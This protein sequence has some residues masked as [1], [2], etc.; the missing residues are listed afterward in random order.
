[1][2]VGVFNR[3]VTSWQSSSPLY[4]SS[5]LAVGVLSLIKIDGEIGLGKLKIDLGAHLTK[6]CTFWVWGGIDICTI[7]SKIFHGQF[8]LNSIRW[9]FKPPNPFL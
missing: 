9:L 4:H 3:E 1:M 8:F 7:S 5:I 2:K 6:K